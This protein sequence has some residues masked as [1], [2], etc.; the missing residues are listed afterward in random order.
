MKK[1]VLF[2]FLLMVASVYADIPLITSVDQYYSVTLDEEGEA[3]V[4]LRMNIK[5]MDS[6]DMSNINIEIPG[7][8]VSLLGAMQETTGSEEQVCQSWVQG[9]TEYGSGQACVQY[10]YNG[11]C[12]TYEKPCLKY[13]N[14]CESYRTIRNY[15]TIYKKI[16]VKPIQQSN[17]VL[18]PVTFLSAVRPQGQTNIV[19]LYKVT[20][21]VDKGMGSY[22]FEFETAKVPLM[23]QNVRVAVNV[24][25]GLYLKGTR[26]NVNYQPNFKGI[27][28]AMEAD[29][30]TQEYSRAVTQYASSITYASGLVKTAT[31]LDP[32][33]SFS[34]RGKY[35]DSWAKINMGRIFFGLI[36][37]IGIVLFLVYGFRKVSNYAK[38]KL[39]QK[40]AGNEHNFIVPFLSGLFTAIAMSVL[41]IVILVLSNLAND[42]SGMDDL[43]ILLIILI[44]VLLTLAMLIG[45]PVYTGMRFGGTQAIFTIISI[46]GWIFVFAIIIF[47]IYS[48]FFS[49]GGVV[50]AAY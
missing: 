7:N 24:Q 37:L 22:D 10:D 28:Q 41:W 21:Y 14:V 29:T 49:N 36:L 17:S 47:F 13:G 35:A 19:L 25:G 11:N 1:I 6:T 18:L 40:K 44:G 23:T 34:V 30:M 16:D 48:L 43:F 38:E 8:S 15:Q 2:M 20:G 3:I 4:S 31:Y 50:Y 9:C 39:P 33:E 46:L 32:H 27:S 42:V 12:V 26:S 5:N 45:V